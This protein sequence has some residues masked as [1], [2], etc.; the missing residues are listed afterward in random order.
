M[1]KNSSPERMLYH[2]Q[3]L[4]TQ[5]ASLPC[6]DAHDCLNLLPVKKKQDKHGGCD[7]DLSLYRSIIVKPLHLSHAK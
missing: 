1:S 3:A 2:I 7:F 4:D 6:E 5:K